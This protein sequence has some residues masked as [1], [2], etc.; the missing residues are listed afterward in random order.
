VTHPEVVAVSADTLTDLQV[1]RLIGRALV[2]G[3]RQLGISHNGFGFDDLS[4]C[5][6]AGPAQ[7]RLDPDVYEAVSNARELLARP[8]ETAGPS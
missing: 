5:L 4:E 1:A 3:A 6:L 2:L 7:V 8:E